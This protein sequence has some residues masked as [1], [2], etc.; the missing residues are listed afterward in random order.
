MNLFYDLFQ[1]ITITITS[2][3]IVVT[4]T[5]TGQKPIPTS[6][7]STLVKIS[8]SPT[9]SPTPTS[10]PKLQNKVVIK[11]TPIPSSTTNRLVNSNNVQRELEL[12]NELKKVSSQK[13]VSTEPPSPV[14]SEIECEKQIK[15]IL[16]K[17]EASYIDWW[18]QFQEARKTISPCYQ[19][20]STLVCDRK[21]SDL[22]V[23]WQ[24]KITDTINNYKKSLSSCNPNDIRFSKYSDVIST[25]Y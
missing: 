5:F 23:E 11:T 14:Y 7:P 20:E 13:Q 25:S 6:T 18:N 16:P 8:P 9:T 17:V 15:E 3:F 19:Q 2:I 21:L 24:N 1:K 4:S 12:K 10:S 22:N